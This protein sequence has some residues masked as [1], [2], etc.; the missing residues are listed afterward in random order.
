MK[1]LRSFVHTLTVLTLAAVHA[2]TVFAKF[3]EIPNT[4]IGQKDETG[5][6]QDQAELRVKENTLY[7]PQGISYCNEHM[8]VTDRNNSRV[9]AYKSILVNGKLIFNKIPDIVLGQKDLV[10]NRFTE[11]GQVA[12][13]NR[14]SIP[15]DVFCD[16]ENLYV[17]DTGYHR[18]LVWKNA[19]DVKTGQNADIV[20]GQSGFLN[21]TAGTTPERMNGPA[22]IWVSRSDVLVADTNNHRVQIFSKSDVLNYDG[23]NAIAP[24]TVLG[25]GVG[26][27]SATSQNGFSSPQGVFSDG[28]ILLVADTNN[29][30]ILGWETIPTEPSQKA[31]FVLGQNSFTSNVV[32][33]PRDG[34]H[35]SSPIRVQIQNAKLIVSDIGNGRVLT[36]DWTQ[37]NPIPWPPAPGTIQVLGQLSLSSW[38]GRNPIQNF[39]GPMGVYSPDAITYFVVDRNFNRLVKVGPGGY[40]EVWGQETFGGTGANRAPWAGGMSGPGAAVVAGG[41]YLFP[42]LEMIEF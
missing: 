21:G 16:G 26:V 4:I 6:F 23:R 28:S 22:G 11:T 12:T 27:S 8:F 7:N 14:M 40:E 9:L 39:S 31:D 13:A 38:E 1:S 29:H 3:T 2:P 30:R 10:S 37:N 41:N 20:I 19:K 33:A 15:S 36:Y 25:S 5:S 18:I 24:K 34:T 17:A 32:Q 42:T 35:F